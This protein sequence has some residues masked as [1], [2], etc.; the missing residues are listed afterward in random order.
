M[1]KPNILVIWG[2]D[3]GNSNLRCDVDGLMGYRMGH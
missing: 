2:E 1:G 3:I